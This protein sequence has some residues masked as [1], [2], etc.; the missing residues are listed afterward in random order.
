MLSYR[1]A[2]HYDTLA[3]LNVAPPQTVVQMQKLAKIR[4]TC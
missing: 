3:V 4:F 1:V 2:A